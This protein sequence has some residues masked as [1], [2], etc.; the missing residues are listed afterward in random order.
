M[1]KFLFILLLAAS[2]HSYAQIRPFDNSKP[3]LPWIY[4]P[5]AD[6]SHDFQAYLAYD[7]RGS[8]NFMPQSVVAG[9]RMPMQGA[10]RFRRHGP[11]SMMGVQLLNTSQDLVRS[12]TI[13]ASFSHEI[14]LTRKTKVAL[15]LGAGVFNMRYDDDNL[16]YMDAHDPLL[17]N[18][19]SIFNMHL[20]AGVSL[21]VEEKF[22]AQVAAPYLIKDE[23]V[24]WNEVIVRV[25]YSL[26]L[27]ADVTLIAAGNLDTYNRNLIYGADLRAEWRKMISVLAGA[28]RYKFH[29]GLLLDIKP[30][31]LG[32]TYAMNYH[33]SFD[34]IPTHQ[35]S[36]LSTLSSSR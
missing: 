17:N 14:P 35:I 28:D 32:Y 8:G 25:G 4:N 22:F 33:T 16:V 36:V 21:V 20:N 11:S 29:G 15:G 27:N 26:P 10:K 5:A 34:H 2:L 19:G 1:K 6:L 31:S 7:G 18:N 9:L 23:R 24:N 30:F 13:Q 3:I 12:S